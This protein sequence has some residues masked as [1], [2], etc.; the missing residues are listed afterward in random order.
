MS[1]K[2]TFLFLLSSLILSLSAQQPET[3]KIGLLIQDKACLAARQGAELAVRRANENGGV[4]GHALQLLVRS[5]EGPWGTGSKQAVHLIFEENVWALLGS[6]DGRNAHLV[7]Q[8]AT[9][10]TVVFISAWASDPT[11]SQAFVPWFYNGVPTD[12]Q[13]ADA[14]IDEIYH[15]RKMNRVATITDLTY[16]SNMALKSYLQ[17]L[18]QAGKNEPVQFLWKD[19]STNLNALADQI[20]KSG[21]HAII[22][23]CSP[24]I[25]L[26]LIRLLRQQNMKQPVFGSISILNEDVLSLQELR[27]FDNMLLVPSLLSASKSQIFRQAYQKTYGT[28]PGMVAAYAFDGMNVLIEAIRISGSQDRESIQQSLSKIR[29]EGVTGLVQFDARGNRVGTCGTMM[30]KNGIPEVGSR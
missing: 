1:F 2:F 17:R 6:H 9:K 28:S 4:N 27:E 11:L 21:T 15:K 23:F 25:S 10:S 3:V 18:R 20:N 22:L 14:W 29:Y 13:Q 12:N 19:Y 26:K 5:M 8:A 7:E 24:S 30:V 16:D